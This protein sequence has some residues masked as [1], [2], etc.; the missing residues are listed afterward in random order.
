MPV[1]Q[2]LES[3][4]ISMIKNSEVA[5]IFNSK[6][7]LRVLKKDLGNE[8]QLYYVDLHEEVV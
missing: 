1:Q 6:T 4:V 3:L 2:E 7:R 5:K 8:P